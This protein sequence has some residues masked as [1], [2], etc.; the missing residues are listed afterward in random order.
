M[1]VSSGIP[2]MREQTRIPLQLNFFDRHYHFEISAECYQFFLEDELTESYIDWT[3][4]QVENLLTLSPGII[5][6]GTNCDRIVPVDVHVLSSEPPLTEEPWD[7]L[8]ECS[9]YVPSGHL[10]VGFCE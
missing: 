8:I 3:N 5:A 2:M 4:E 6:V 10:I 7:H 9:N 1:A